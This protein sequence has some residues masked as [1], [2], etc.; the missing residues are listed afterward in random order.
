MSFR[1]GHSCA[2]CWEGQFEGQRK[3]ALIWVSL[4]LDL[5]GDDGLFLL[6]L[7]WVALKT[8]VVVCIRSK[9]AELLGF[10]ASF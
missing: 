4:G 7:K 5:G 2:L 3:H 1:C 10:R 6:F 8:V 9:G